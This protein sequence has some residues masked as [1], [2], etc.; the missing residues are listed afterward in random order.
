MAEEKFNRKDYN[1]MKGV[2]TISRYWTNPKITTILSDESINLSINLDDFISAIKNE[3]PLV[4]WTFKQA[5]FEKQFD[6][7]VATVLEKVKEESI[8]VV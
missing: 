2:I 4:T 3:I 6:S 5:T 7:A 8:K 1:K